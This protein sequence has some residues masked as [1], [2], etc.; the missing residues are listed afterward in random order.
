MTQRQRNAA[1]AFCV[2]AI[3]AL[4][5]SPFGVWG[6]T[7][8]ALAAL[9]WAI[10]RQTQPQNAALIGWVGG[11]GYFCLSL[12]WIV[13]PFFVDAPRDGWMAPFA[14]LIMGFGLAL[15]WAAA[16]AVAVWSK[17]PLLGLVIGLT[18]AELA[19]GYVLTGFPWALVGHIWIDT[20]VAQW[21][22]VLDRQD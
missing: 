18:A 13:S 2:G 15:F 9:F 19:R 10:A 6:A 5:Q 3:A 4:G 1:A 21:A 11:A 8:L 14:L 22:A 7:I 20:P 12:S 17:R 16:A